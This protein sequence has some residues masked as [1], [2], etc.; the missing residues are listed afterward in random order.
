MNRMDD[1]KYSLIAFGK[2]IELI[3]TDRD[4]VEI[5]CSEEEYQL[6]WKDYFDMDYNYNE[7]VTV[8]IQGKDEFLKKAAE[9]GRGLRILKQDIFETLISFI[10]SQRKNI[11]AI[12]SCI[13]Q[14]SVKYGERKVSSTCDNKEYY[15][16]PTPERL[17]GANIEE[18]RKAG[19]GYRDKYILK[20]SQAVLRSDIDII[21][22]RELNSGEAV[23]ELLNLSGVGI[24]VAN[25]VSLYGLHHIE[26]FPVDV[27]IGRIL[28]DIYHNKFDLELYNGFA[29]IVQ[30][31]MF[32]Y[33]RSQ[34]KEDIKP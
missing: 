10:I 12:K 7:I 31:Y 5:T 11:P 6:L 1:N 16:F 24:K 13:E 25:C 34:N 15:T 3:Q 28:K 8:L 17:A 33:I 2:Y 27:W 18:L 29:G 23:R 4:S 19:L 32:Y 21:K 26:S 30:Q 22:L 9:F 20:T 14:L